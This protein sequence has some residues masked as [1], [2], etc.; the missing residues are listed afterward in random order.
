MLEHSTVDNCAIC[1]RGA[2][3]Y[4]FGRKM[5]RTKADENAPLGT[6]GDWR[7]WSWALAPGGS[8]FS[9]QAQGDIVRRT[10]V[11]PLLYQARRRQHALRR[12][13]NRPGRLV[14]VGTNGIWDGETG[15]PKAHLPRMLRIPAALPQCSA[16]HCIGRFRQAV[17][18][19]NSFPG[20]TAAMTTKDTTALH[21]PS[22]PPVTIGRWHE[23]RWPEQ[24]RVPPPHT[25]FKKALGGVVKPKGMRDGTAF[26][27]IHRPVSSIW[28]SPGPERW[29]RRQKLV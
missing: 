15:T 8:P 20:T 16:L 3:L 28:A 26:G 13:P 22:G 17:S 19:S 24:P 4:T 23:Q 25:V 10:P 2:R 29:R 5:I 11:R 6:A 18:G 21:Q 12:R 1:Q 9:S 7:W 27:P 14:P